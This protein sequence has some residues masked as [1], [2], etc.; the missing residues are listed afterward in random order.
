M[1]TKLCEGGLR[2]HAQVNTACTGIRLVQMQRVAFDR[3]LQ[4]CAAH[5]LV[6]ERRKWLCPISVDLPHSHLSNCVCV[7]VCLQSQLSFLQALQAVASRSCIA[8]IAY[9]QP[10][11]AKAP[12]N[13]A[14]PHKLTPK[15]QTS[16]GGPHAWRSITSGGL[17]RTGSECSGCGSGAPAAVSALLSRAWPKS[18]TCVKCYACK[19]ST[20]HR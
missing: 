1:V 20:R 2:A 14:V 19:V 15:A 10:L 4:R 9:K 18:A 17:Q 13:A 5:P 16:L 8:C 7:F 12:A 6:V 11:P 3:A